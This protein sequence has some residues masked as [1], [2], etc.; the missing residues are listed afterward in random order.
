MASR[1]VALVIWAAAAASAVFWGYRLFVKPMAV[2]P[3]A[4]VVVARRP[5]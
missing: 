5:E 1:L 3:Q 4:T 2:P